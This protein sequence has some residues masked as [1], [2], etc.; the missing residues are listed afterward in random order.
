MSMADVQTA[1]AYAKLAAVPIQRYASQ[2]GPNSVA[3]SP[4]V[5]TFTA[6]LSGDSFTDGD[7]QDWVDQIAQTAQ[8]VNP[9]HR[10][11]ARPVTS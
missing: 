2:Y 11:S 8:V 4:S 9:V 1:A 7:L 10:R 5:L 3:V 6:A